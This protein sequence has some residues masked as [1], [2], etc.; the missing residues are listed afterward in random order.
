MWS[1][2]YYKRTTATCNYCGLTFANNFFRSKEVHAPTDKKSVVEN[3]ATPDD[4]NTQEN[5]PAADK[6]KAGKVALKVALGVMTGGVSLIP[7]AVNAVKKKDK[8]NEN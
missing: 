2:N 7:D 3:L 5:K 8:E 1:I 4:E 6:S